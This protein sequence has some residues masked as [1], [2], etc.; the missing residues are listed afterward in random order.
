MTVT[1]IRLG[2]ATNSSSSHSI[3][4]NKNRKKEEW[5]RITKG[6]YGDTEF[7]WG[8]FILDSP[9]RKLPYICL[10]LL[11]DKN[12]TPKEKYNFET[13]R[14]ELD[15]ERHLGIFNF[16]KGQ[17]VTDHNIISFYEWAF[18]GSQVK[19][20]GALPRLGYIDH[21]SH[22]IISFSKKF[23]KEELGF[24]LTEYLQY[25]IYNDGVI[26]FGGNDNDS[27]T[28]GIQ[29]KKSTA[30]LGQ[31]GQG[32]IWIKKDGTNKVLFN[33]NTGTKIRSSKTGVY[34][35][36][37]TPE[38][39]DIKVTDYCSYG[40]TFCYQGSTTNGKHARL[41][42]IIKILDQLRELEVFEVAYGGGE[43]AAH[44]QFK[45][46]LEE[47]RARNIIPNFTAYGFQWVP[48]ADTVTKVCGS[49][50]VS[51]SD[52]VGINKIKRMNNRLMF[53]QTLLKLPRRPNVV[54]Q[55]VMETRPISELR[56]LV[57]LLGEEE[58]STLRHILLLGYKTTGRG[59]DFHR[60]VP[61]ESKVE[62]LL[63][64]I[65]DEGKVTLSVDTAFL[66]KYGAILDKLG[67]QTYLRSSPEGKFSM[68][69]DAVTMTMAKSS[70]VTKDEFVPYG[71]N[72]LTSYS[73]W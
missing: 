50:G 46:I 40:C 3:V 22:G 25:L 32:R 8:N 42:D 44:P 12:F 73:K 11:I 16:L 60:V 2:F 62:E 10:A 54:A 45:E 19:G 9:N 6:H 70:Y 35:K 56:D 71:N 4:F 64:Y 23:Y 72:L 37:T 59:K 41:E 53:M 28:S 24:K 1:S 61:H 55:Y 30:T 29:A 7:G 38:L 58:E 67:I 51:I 65:I 69:I 14:V 27:D 13:E 20:R 36:S 47:T 39:V 49:I 31:H 33:P 5:T 15:G 52:E 63:K 48:Y 68:Y 34:E 57:N 18:D 21:Q 43:P 17:N 26:I 66:D